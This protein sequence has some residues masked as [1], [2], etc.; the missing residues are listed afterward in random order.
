[1]KSRNYLRTKVKSYKGKINAIF[2]NGK[3]PKEGFHC[4]WLSM[5]I[6]YSVFKMDSNCYSQVFLEECN[7]IIKEKEIKIYIKYDLEM[8]SNKE[9]VW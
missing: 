2:H 3:I 4:I 7:Y 9:I 1:M 5:T 8:S 6:I